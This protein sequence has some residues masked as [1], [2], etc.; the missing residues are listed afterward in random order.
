M[1]EA[2]S[3]IHHQPA[4]H[5]RSGALIDRLRAS[6]S[7]HFDDG[8]VIDPDSSDQPGLIS[9]QRKTT[10]F[11][12][13]SYGGWGKSRSLPIAQSLTKCSEFTM[14]T[15]SLRLFRQSIPLWTSR[16]V[17]ASARIRRSASMAPSKPICW[18]CAPAETGRSILVSMPA[19]RSAIASSVRFS[20][21]VHA[22]WCLRAIRPGSSAAKHV[23]YDRSQHVASACRV[24]LISISKDP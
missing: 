3:R 11:E 17:S 12:S 9:K 14:P 2:D 18:R 7:L 15:P 1:F 13:R 8:I 20:P 16:S 4:P 24:P 23:G 19:R 5:A 22:R 21:H 6:A 10:F